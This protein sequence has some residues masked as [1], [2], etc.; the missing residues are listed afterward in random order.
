MQY[1]AMFGV[2]ADLTTVALGADQGVELEW[3]TSGVTIFPAATWV[4]SELNQND[5]EQKEA[6]TAIIKAA[7]ALARH[8]Q[9]E[10]PAARETLRLEGELWRTI[11][12]GKISPTGDFIEQHRAAKRMKHDEG[13]QGA[14]TQAVQPKSM[15]ILKP[16]VWTEGL[17]EGMV[18]KIHHENHM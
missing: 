1:I 9:T 4:L 6:H 8:L 14:M 12:V 7:Q 11:G 16:T 3:K 10:S 5:T 18:V 13:M 15:E 17:K 2:D